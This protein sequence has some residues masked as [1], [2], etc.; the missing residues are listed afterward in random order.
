MKK[1]FRDVFLHLLCSM[2]FMLWIFS[3]WSD[4]DKSSKL[5]TYQKIS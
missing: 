4:G 3:F 5:A 1:D 2:W